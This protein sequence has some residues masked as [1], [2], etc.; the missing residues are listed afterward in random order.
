MS[1]KFMN[2]S[3]EVHIEVL[4]T[5]GEAFNQ[6]NADGLVALMTDDCVFRT[7]M[8]EHAGGNSIMGKTAVREAFV[9]TFAAFPDAQWVPRGT[10]MVEGNRGS[11]EWTFVATRKSDG[12][13]FEMDGV[14]MFTFQDGKIAIKDAYRKDRPPQLKT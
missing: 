11:T 14:D 13:L 4:K 3:K 10:I 8:G 6:H 5:F 7:A 9:Q 1:G 2:Q 12:A